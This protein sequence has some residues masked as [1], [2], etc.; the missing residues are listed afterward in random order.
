MLAKLLIFLSRW[1]S[2]IFYVCTDIQ[3]YAINVDQFKIPSTVFYAWSIDTRWKSII[4]P[5]TADYY[6]GLLDESHEKKSIND[7]SV[8]RS[9]KQTIFLYR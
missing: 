6:D 3:T 2:V 1:I 5:E 4:P 8:I 9:I 7:V